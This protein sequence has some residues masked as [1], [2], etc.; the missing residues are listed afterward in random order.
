MKTCPACAEQIPSNVETCPHCGISL[1]DYSPTQG[2]SGGGRKTSGTMI[3]LIVVGCVFGVLVVCGGILAA[4]L[5]PAVQQAREAARRSQCQNNL[6]QI[7]LALLNYE[8]TYGSFPP[9]FIPD[10]SGKPMHSW[11]VLILPYLDQQPLYNAYNFS[12][13]WDGP[14]NSRLLASMPP[15][16]ACPSHA[17]PPG[18]TNTAYV[19]PYGEHCI[20]RGSQPVGIRDILDGTSNTVMVGEAANANIPWMKPDDVDIRAHPTIGDRDG[21]SSDHAG[22]VHFL[23]GDGSVRFISQSITQQTLQALFTRD[24]GEVIGG[25]F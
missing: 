12:E 18:N 17:G 23:L 14:N 25:D 20:F 8:T 3:V 9:A 13:P 15:T 24:G 22:G 2:S 19:A 6:K 10:E 21:F 4:L 16:Y 7:G 1:H 11:R 5:L